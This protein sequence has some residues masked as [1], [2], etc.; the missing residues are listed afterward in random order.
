MNINSTS[1]TYETWDEQT[2]QEVTRQLKD[3]I[4]VLKWG[5]EQ[6]T[7]KI[8]Y[9]CSFGVEGIV[10]IDLIDKVQPNAKIVFLD[11]GL[12]FKETYDL[13][14]KV[15]DRYPQLDI[16]Q[17]KPAF[18]VAE[19]ARIYGD[20]LWKR[21]PNLC[22]QM[23][24]IE[25]LKQVLK[26]YKAWISGLRREQSPARRH[27]EFVNKDEKF[28][29][30]KICPLIHWTTEEIWAYVELNDLPYNELHD[31]GYPSIGCLPCTTPATDPNDSR[32]GRWAGLEKTECG[33]HQ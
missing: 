25:P 21:N 1:L 2:V 32:S 16:E 28:H 22:C 4:E 3:S 17:V 15:K 29:L 5:Y 6:Y 7:D 14:E 27:M 12:H 24:K 31:R 33:L 30:I 26:G 19:Q 9:A 10:L 13:I 8:I 11:T 20:E 18:T 23:R